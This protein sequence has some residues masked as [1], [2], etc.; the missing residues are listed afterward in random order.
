MSCLQCH[1]P[2]GPN[3]KIQNAKLRREAEVLKKGFCPRANIVPELMK[4]L[5]AAQQRFIEYINKADC[6]DRISANIPRLKGLNHYL[7]KLAM[8]LTKAFV[9]LSK[10]T[11]LAL[12]EKSNI[13]FRALSFRLK[14]LYELYPNACVSPLLNV[15]CVMGHIDVSFRNIIDN[16]RYLFDLSI[17][18]YSWTAVTQRPGCSRRT[19]SFAYE[20][21]I[22]GARNSERSPIIWQ[23]RMDRRIISKIEQRI[24]LSFPHSI[25]IRKLC[26]IKHNKRAAS[27]KTMYSNSP[28]SSLLVSN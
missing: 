14:G 18:C 16:L 4:K 26:C 2:L 21:S 28:I 17:F 6:M 24:H 25:V 12:D 7:D 13:D 3:Y 1:P 27:N 5:N 15:G 9:S 10:E 19:W 11:C 20:S 8:E 23:R 22:N